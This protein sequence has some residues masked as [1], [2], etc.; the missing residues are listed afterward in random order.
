MAF[1]LNE[2]KFNER[3]NSKIP[4]VC[5]INIPASGLF[6]TYFPVYNACTVSIC[7][8]DTVEAAFLM[9]LSS[10]IISEK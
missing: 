10:K 8:H 2:K 4:M 5:L 1:N 6:G 7:V 9:H 3:V